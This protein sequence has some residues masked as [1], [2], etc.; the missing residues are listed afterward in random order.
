MATNPGNTK[1]SGLRQEPLLFEMEDLESVGRFTE[2][3]AHSNGLGRFGPAFWTE[4]GAF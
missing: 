1:R 4:L 2:R 3:Q